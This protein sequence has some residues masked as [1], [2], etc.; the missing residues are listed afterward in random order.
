MRAKPQDIEHKQQVALFQWAR[1][2]SKAWPELDLMFAVP[3]GARTS[4]RTA[5]KLKAEG[6]KAGVPDICLPVPRKGFGSLFIEMKRKGGRLQDSQKEWAT[7]LIANGNRV[8]VC[9]S[10]DEAISVISDYLN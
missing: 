4:I 9:Y 3:N 7:Q 2:Q 1:L 6:M 8:A 10:T 5:V